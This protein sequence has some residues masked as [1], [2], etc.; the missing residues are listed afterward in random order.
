MKNITTIGID[1]AKNVFQVHAA[2][3]FGNK[4]WSKKVKR[5]KLKELLVNTPVS[6]IGMEACCGAHYWGREFKAMGHEV[7]LMNPQFVKPYVKNNKNDARDAE[8]I[9]EAVTRPTMRFIP[10][11]TAAQQNLGAVHTVRTGLVSRRTEVSNRLRGLL[12]E[13]GVI[14]KQGHAALRACL[15]EVL[16]GGV[17]ALYPVPLWIKDMHEELISLDKRIKIYD[18]ELKRHSTVS[19]T[20]KRLLEIP[21]VGK[22]TASAIEA[23]IGDVSSFKSGRDLAA[24][25]GLVPKQ[26]SSGGKEQMG[27]ISKRGD[28]YLRTLLIHGARA[29]IQATLKCHKD[30]STLYHCWIIETVNRIGKNKA[31]VALANKH[32]R[33]IWAMLKHKRSFNANFAEVFLQKVA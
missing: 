8:A 31:A 5:D 33:I 23:K 10:I 26:N 4:I 7:K 13:F 11:K 6:L 21:G 15:A 25:L 3:C 1:L 28:R 29:E 2:D 19:E 18:D 22:V 9:T 24:F 16:L 30:G 20:A 27:G 32:A 14:C 12:V 17:E